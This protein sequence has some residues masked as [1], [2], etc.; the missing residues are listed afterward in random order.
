MTKA[1]FISKPTLKLRAALGISFL[2]TLSTIVTYWPVRGFDF[3]SFDDNIYVT[4]NR[5]VRNGLIL[6]SIRWSIIFAEK[7]RTYWH[8]LTWLSHMLDVQLYGLNPRG[9]HLSNVLFHTANILLL[10]WL[11]HYMTGALWRSAL[12]AALFALHP[13]NVESVA[14]VSERKNVLSTFFWMLTLWAYVFY[15]FKPN[16][17][18]YLTVIVAFLLGLLAKPMLVTLPFVLLLIDYWPLRRLALNQSI[19]GLDWKYFLILEKLP[20]MILSGLSVYLSSASI[21][22]MGNVISLES[23]PMK[24]RIA[25]ALVSYLKYLG[26]M[27]WPH[28][29]AV[30][31]PYPRI[32]LPWQIAGS[33]ALLIGISAGVIWFLR[34]FPYLTVGWLWFLGTLVPVSGLVQ[35]GLWPALADRWAYVPVIGL[36]IAFA[37]GLFSLGSKWRSRNAV[38][39]LVGCILLGLT[40]GVTRFQ[41]RYWA[42]SVK[43]FRHALAVTENNALAHNMLANSLAEAGQYQEAVAHIMKGLKIKPNNAG[44]YNNLGNIL[45]DQGK[46]D[47]A[48]KK[49]RKA[50]EMNIKL[51][52]AHYNLGVALALKGNNHAAIEHYLAALRLDPDNVKIHNNLANLL[53]EQGKIEKALQHYLTALQLNPHDSELYNNFGVALIQIGKL[54]LAIKQFRNALRINPGYET[55]RGNLAKTMQKLQK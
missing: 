51:E 14:W 43:L 25:N 29:L 45:L 54:R 11:L 24:L 35:V 27:L 30:F 26:K 3:T 40:I 32:V 15:T 6:D 18:R 37:W 34:R 2:L 47:E 55:A 49:F 36:F 52:T 31:Y 39:V 48:I 42:D 41:I 9:H 28:K 38:L 23:V 1:T 21:Q 17:V 10:F 19:R 50:L 22:G 53:L 5:Y 33:V 4:D 12:V 20:L 46:L 7:E 44:A 16:P 13:I 8:P